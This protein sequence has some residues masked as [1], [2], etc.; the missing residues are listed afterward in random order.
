M[1]SLSVRGIEKRIGA[2]SILQGISFECRDGEFLVLVGPSG[3]GKSTLLNCIAGL[4]APTAG[5]IHLGDRD[6]T[7]LG[8]RDRN[9]AMVF[10]S[11]A[12]YPTMTVRENLSFALEMRKVP[13]A[14][15]RKT[16]LEVAEAL[17]ITALLDRKPAQLSGGQKQR[18]AIGRALVRKPSLFLFDEPLSNLDAKLRLEMRAEIKRLHRE[19][20]VTM[21]YVT[22]DQV[23]AMTLGDRIAV[24]REGRVLQID[25]PLEVYER[26]SSSFVAA[27][28]GSPSMNF[29]PRPGGT[30]GFRPEDARLGGDGGFGFEASVDLVEPTGPDTLVHLMLETGKVIL[31]VP[32]REAP[33]AGGRVKVSIP[34]ERLHWFDAAG[35]RVSPVSQ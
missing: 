35:A 14:E 19:L 5:S 3:C 4:D 2:T 24:L 18:V 10:Q 11:Y 17:K 31:Q 28:I 25:K 15:R 27:F 29:L 23:E 21:V 33:P 8:P 32:S 1:A 30:V 9:V 26:P 22:H 7:R 20:G 16:V 12:L 34:S 6:V 13:K